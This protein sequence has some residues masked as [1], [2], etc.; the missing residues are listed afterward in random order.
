MR[1]HEVEPVEIDRLASDVG[2]AVA[3]L[4]AGARGARL[5]VEINT[6]SLTDT[7]YAAAVIAETN[8]LSEDAARAADDADALL[9]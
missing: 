5:N 3:L 9:R 7:A 6:G 1:P 2:V 8:R 4:R